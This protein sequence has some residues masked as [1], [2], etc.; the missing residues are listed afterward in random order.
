MTQF[1]VFGGGW[2]Q[3]TT[4]FGFFSFHDD[5]VLIGLNASLYIGDKETYQ[6]S[7]K[8]INFGLFDA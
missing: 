7:F 2:V 5:F 1:R 6:K 8:K 3:S 4:F